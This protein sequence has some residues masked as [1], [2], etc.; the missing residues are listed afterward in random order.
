MIAVPALI[1]SLLIFV[2][3]T[4]CEKFNS[5]VLTF[6]QGQGKGWIKNKESKSDLCVTSLNHKYFRNDLEDSLSLGRPLLLED[7]GEELDPALD[8]I[9]E[10]NFIKSGKNLKV[11]IRSYLTLYIAINYTYKAVI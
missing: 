10:K 4:L 2:I 8:N 7:I 1:K 5:F 11:N 9:L 6:F 3:G